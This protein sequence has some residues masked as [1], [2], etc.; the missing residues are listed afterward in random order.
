M[1]QVLEG[2]FVY[3][4]A[5]TVSIDRLDEMLACPAPL[6]AIPN[7]S[8]TGDPS[9]IVAMSKV[10]SKQWIGHYLAGRTSTAGFCS[11]GIASRRTN[12]L[13]SGTT[14]GWHGPGVAGTRISHRS[15]V[16]WLIV[17]STTRCSPI[18]SMA[19]SAIGPDCVASPWRSGT[20]TFHKAVLPISWCRRRSW[21]R[22]SLASAR[23]GRLSPDM[24]G[25]FASGRILGILLR[26]WIAGT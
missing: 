11:S 16:L 25:K 19:R 7:H 26:D 20:I 8:G 14:S 21:T 12:L 24:I 13:V 9:E 4:D 15:T 3:F 18:G 22:Q 6:A 2:D 23:H 5:D 1:R 10:S 17:G